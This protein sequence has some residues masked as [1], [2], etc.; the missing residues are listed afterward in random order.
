MASL[1]Y[2]AAEESED[3]LNAFTSPTL[4]IN[5]LV[6]ILQVAVCV[7]SEDRTPTCVFRSAL[8]D[9]IKNPGFI[10]I[11][12]V[13]PTKK[14]NSRHASDTPTKNCIHLAAACLPTGFCRPSAHTPAAGA[15]KMK[16]VCPMVP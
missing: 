7:R 4:P 2:L 8:R 13:E 14:W 12:S 11:A 3:T 9:N 1:R 5:G 16:K 6:V 10:L 15:P